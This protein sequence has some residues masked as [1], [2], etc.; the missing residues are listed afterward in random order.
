MSTDQTFNFTLPDG[1]RE[2]ASVA[3]GALGCRDVN[4]HLPEDIA[5]DAAKFIKYLRLR[6]FSDADHFA[7]PES[8]VSVDGSGNR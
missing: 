6:P 7:A 3:A 8:S 2:P 1:T 5:T 4:V